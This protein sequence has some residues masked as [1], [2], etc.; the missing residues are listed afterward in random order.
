M[1]WSVFLSLSPLPVFSSL[2]M[3]RSVS[4]T[5]AGQCRL[6]PLIQVIL[7]CS[8]LYDYTVKLLFKL[9]SCEWNTPLLVKL[10]NLKAQGKENAVKAAP[11]KHSASFKYLKDLE[12]LHINFKLKRHDTYHNNSHALFMKL[13][14]TRNPYSQLLMR[15]TDM[16][17]GSKH[18]IISHKKLAWFRSRAATSSVIIS[19]SADY[20][21]KKN[22][23]ISQFFHSSDL[24]WLSETGS[25]DSTTTVVSDEALYCDSGR[26][27]G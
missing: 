25:T 27:R 3:S 11:W 8:H 13:F 16:L 15:L 2:D 7:D 22:R 17:P 5:A 14:I 4:V 20:L 21:K 10:H 18:L 9:H 12:K 23:I 6:A 24:Q 1:Y 26:N 19:W